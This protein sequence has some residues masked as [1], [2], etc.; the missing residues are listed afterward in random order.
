MRLITF[1]AALV[2][3]VFH[4]AL[5]FSGLVPNLVSRPLHLA[6]AL[7]WI[8][9]AG[10]QSRWM[11]FS[12]LA[13]TVIGVG[14]SVWVALSHNMLADQYGFLE[15]RYQFWIAAAL[16]I[17]GGDVLCHHDRP[18]GHRRDASERHR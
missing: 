5:I 4:L 6:M 2:L 12:G 17:V 8:L 11:Y 14:C 9:L 15:G 10:G 1:L 16:L 7:P 18:D 13:L 3:V